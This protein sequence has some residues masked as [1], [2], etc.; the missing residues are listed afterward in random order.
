MTSRKKAA[1]L[2][3]RLAGSEEEAFEQE[4]AAVEIQRSWARDVADG[5]EQGNLPGKKSERRLAAAILRLWADQLRVAK[6]K[7]RGNPQ[8]ARKIYDPD[9]AAL[10]V[11][12]EI[13]FGADPPEAIRRV[14][15]YFELNDSTIAKIFR[16]RRS[17]VAEWFVHS[18]LAHRAGA[19]RDE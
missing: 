4:A 2:V 10:R 13:A 1:P 6:P 9:E 12:F 5:I 7:K 15:D 18:N 19:I 3:I 8:F 11:G 17:A 14:A 16:A